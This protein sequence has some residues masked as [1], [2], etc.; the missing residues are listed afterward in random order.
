MA[1]PF[2]ASGTVD[3]EFFTD[4]ST[5]MR[6]IRTALTQPASKLLV[7]G[8]RRMGKSSAIQR[9]VRRIGRAGGYA[10]VADLSTSSTVADMA[11]RL[12]EAATK[13]LG[14][15]WREAATELARRVGA[16]LKLTPDPASGLVLPSFEI[17]L[18]RA[19]IE[20]QRESLGRVLDAINDMA[21]ARDLTV[22]VALDEF[23]EIAKFGGEDA[24]WHLRG[25]IQHHQHASYILAGSKPHL[26]RRML[27]KERAFYDMLDVLHFG[28]MDPAH[29][30]RW[31]EH[32]MANAGVQATGTGERIVTVAGPRTRDIVQLALRTYDITARAGVAHPIDVDAAFRELVDD[33]DDLARTFWGGLTPN[34]QNV[35]RAVAVQPTGLT[36]SDTIERFGLT[37]SSAVTQALAVFVDDGR[38][39]RNEAG[40]DYRFDSPFLRGW[41]IVNALPDLGIML[42]ATYRPPEL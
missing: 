31:I 11:N 19:N 25:V 10:L 20:E 2:R 13:A 6:R 23:Q 22:G 1:N 30:T 17:G 14:R 9:A 34:Q 26:I 41:V 38:L 8:H 21:L 36:T 3:N 18:R 4:R 33:R 29:L 5:E 35:L 12:L 28:P 37:N 27:D 24:E 42:P 7:Y 40:V 16:T 32:R 15:T 39:V